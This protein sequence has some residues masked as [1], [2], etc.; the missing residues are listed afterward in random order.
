MIVV[1]MG[2]SVDKQN[3]RAS[4]VADDSTDPGSTSQEALCVIDHSHRIIDQIQRF[5]PRGFCD[6]G[7][8]VAGVV[9]EESAAMREGLAMIQKVPVV[10]ECSLA[11]RHFDCCHGAFAVQF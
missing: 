1:A 4:W 10:A 7:I 5:N 8:G 2:K 6:I 11:S 9:I 3:S